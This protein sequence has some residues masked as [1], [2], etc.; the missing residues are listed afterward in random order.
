M[1]PSSFSNFFSVYL[2]FSI[3]CVFYVASLFGLKNGTSAPYFFAMRAIFSESVSTITRSI[4]SQDKAC[5]TAYAIKGLPKK[6][7][8]FLFLILVEPDRAGMYAKIFMIIL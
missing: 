4:K 3:T 7:L 1:Y 8:I 5:S 6:F 2:I